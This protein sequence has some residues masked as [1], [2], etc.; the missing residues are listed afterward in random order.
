[1]NT[2]IIIRDTISANV[3]KVIDSCQPC[4]QT[5]ETN[6][7]DVA[8]VVIICLTILFFT[9]I[10]TLALYLNKKDNEKASNMIDKLKEEKKTLENSLIKEKENN[11]QS[12]KALEIL[13]EFVALSKCKDEKVDFNSIDKLYNIHIKIK[14]S[15]EE[16]KI[17]NKQVSEHEEDKKTQNKE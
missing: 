16:D 11:N 4:I 2:L 8:I 7:I 12:T 9:G 6:C 14:E 3:V 13:K 10:I 17:Q 15:L 5:T 1:M